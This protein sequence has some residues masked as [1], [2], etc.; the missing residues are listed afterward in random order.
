MLTIFRRHLV[1]CIHKD[2]GR[3]WRQCQCPISVE[4]YLGDTRIRQSLEVRS[5]EIAQQKVRDLEAATLFPKEEE[6]EVKLVSIADAIA[7]FFRDARERGLAEATINKYRV[8]LD[9]QLF[10]FAKGRGFRFVSEFDLDSVRDFKSTWKDS[11]ISAA[12]KLERLKAF[13]RFCEDSGWIPANPAQKVKPPKVTNSP[14]LP[15]SKAEM[16]KIMWACDLYPDHPRG[17]RKRVRAMVLLLRYSG[18]RIRDGILLR[19]DSIQDGLLFLRTSKTGT[20][21]SLPLPEEVTNALNDVIGSHP[22]YFFHNGVVKPEHALSVWERTMKRLFEIAGVKGA[23]AHRFRDTLSVSLLSRG[24]PV[25]DVAAILGNTP[26]V[27]MKH[28]APWVKER[29]LRLQDRVRATRD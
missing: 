19:R 14:T 28:Y 12:K 23:H 26:A 1:S 22:D 27:V 5:W 8:L 2:K 10:A 16:E 21:V 24:V 6:I 13:F 4:G 3:A 25:E 18:L 15:F 9:T 29:Q 7:R 11:P 17:Q 20:A